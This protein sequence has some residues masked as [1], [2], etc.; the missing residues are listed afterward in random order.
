M[1]LEDLGL[2]FIWGLHHPVDS[3]LFKHKKCCFREWK[4][5]LDKKSLSK[6]SSFVTFPGCLG[7]LRICRKYWE[8]CS[9]SHRLLALT[10]GDPH[11][12]PRIAAR[13]LASRCVRTYLKRAF[14]F[15]TSVGRCRKTTLHPGC[16]PVEG[17]FPQHHPKKEQHGFWIYHH[18]W[19]R[20]WWV[21]AG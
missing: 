11:L 15:L 2:L 8:F 20:A 4:P 19:R 5:S 7:L 13:W 12:Y 14:S 1:H 10:V 18:W 21:P 3:A 9:C 17:N 16:I 6:P